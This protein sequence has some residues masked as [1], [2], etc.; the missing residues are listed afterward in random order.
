MRVVAFVGKTGTGKSYHSMSVAHSN[1]I[2]CIIDDGL[3]IYGSKIIA[4]SSAKHE[5]TRIASVKRAVFT[6]KTHADEVRRALHE[7]GAKSVM[8]IG[9]SENMTNTIISRLGLPAAEKVI[10]IED[11]ASTQDMATAAYMR[12]KLGKHVI[13]A[14]T[15]EVKKQFSGYFLNPLILMLRRRSGRIERVEKTIM[16]PSYSYL[17]D[18]RIAPRVICSICAYEIRRTDGIA[19]VLRTKSAEDENGCLEITADIS[20]RF[21]CDIP[22]TAEK[23]KKVICRS[24][25]DSTSMIVKKVNIN[26][27]NIVIDK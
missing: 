16:R 7:C 18:F 24:V 14:P 26:F 20:L 25:E 12:N 15:F 17:G 13:P 8:V 11:V 10:H 27:K 3:L 22:K 6:D 2:D 4:G 5:K 9:T 19:G 21:P 1:N 23:I